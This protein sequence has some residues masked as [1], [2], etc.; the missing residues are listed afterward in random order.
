MPHWPHE[1][2]DVTAKFPSE[3]GGDRAGARRLRFGREK[4]TL[5]LETSSRPQRRLHVRLAQHMS[6]ATQLQID[7][8]PTHK[9]GRPFHGLPSTAGCV[10]RAV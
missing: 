9:A 5:T 10:N 6:V 1:D 2:V 7:E 4:T 3:L 8:R